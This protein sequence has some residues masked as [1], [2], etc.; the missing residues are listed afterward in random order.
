MSKFII[1]LTGGIGSGKTTAANIFA[2]Y[3]I[4]VI[5]ADQVAREL[6]APDQPAYHAIVEKL[7][8]DILKTDHTLNRAK[9]RDLTFNDPALKKWLEALLH[10]EV[11]KIM[12][13]KALQASSPY[14]ILMIPLLL[15]TAHYPIINRV[16]VIDADEE[17][18]LIRVKNRDN[19]TDEQVKRI[20]ASQIPRAERLRKA[21]DI[22]HNSGD[23]QQL[24]DAVEMM[25]QKYLHIATT[26]SGHT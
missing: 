15:E 10:P 1:G 11:R 26:C 4:N 3:G 13:E 8:S 19:M 20:I 2:S 25:H 7:G 22:I 17:R 5:D 18:Q 23:L 9:L 6:V 16:L 12:Q 24:S 14:C 21:D